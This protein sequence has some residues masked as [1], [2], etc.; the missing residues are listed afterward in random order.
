MTIYVARRDLLHVRGE[1]ARN[2]ERKMRKNQ[3]YG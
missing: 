3:T 2:P 1:G